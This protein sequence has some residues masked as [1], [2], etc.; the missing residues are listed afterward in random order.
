MPSLR[1]KTPVEAMKDDQAYVRREVAATWCASTNQMYT[2]ISD[3]KCV[4]SPI[5]KFLLA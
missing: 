3:G 5:M 4:I 1:Q 2:S